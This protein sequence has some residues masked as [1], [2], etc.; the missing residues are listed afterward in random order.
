MP[1][2]RQNR[3][4]QPSRR[5][6]PQSLISRQPERH[7]VCTYRLLA[8]RS[9]YPLADAVLDMHSGDGNE[10]LN[11]IWVGYYARWQPR[12]HCAVKSLSHGLRFRTSLHSTSYRQ[13]RCY[14]GRICCCG[15]GYPSIDVEAGG[16]NIVDTDAVASITAGVRRTLAHLGM[17]TEVFVP[18]QQQKMIH[19]RSWISAPQSGSCPEQAGDWVKQDEL[20]GI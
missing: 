12:R 14:L 15:L 13:S 4:Y 2:P 8:N 9:L 10:D 6:E 1:A 7:A 20:L 18:L 3:L 5:Q 17:T 19:D 16:K 11:P